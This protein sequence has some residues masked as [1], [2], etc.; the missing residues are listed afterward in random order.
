ML[1][2]RESERAARPPR[3][4]RPPTCTSVSLLCMGQALSGHALLQGTTLISHTDY[5]QQGAVQPAQPCLEPWA[6]A[7][8]R[9]ARESL[10]STSLSHPNV[11]STYKIC[12]IRVGESCHNSKDS[13]E[14]AEGHRPPPAQAAEPPAAEEPGAGAVTALLEA[15]AVWGW[16][17]FRVYGVQNPRIWVQCGKAVLGLHSAPCA[18]HLPLMHPAAPGAGEGPGEALMVSCERGSLCI[19]LSCVPPASPVIQ[20]GCGARAD[21][22]ADGVLRPREPERHGARQPLPA[23]AR[24]RARHVRHP[25]LPHRCGRRCAAASCHGSCFS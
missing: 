1:L 14:P 8:R 25:A 23:Q 11:V 21:V 16:L 17:G 20:R 5:L 19:T 7:A 9:V 6:P 13:A 2:Y 22:A 12:T 3:R 18:P 10:L 24:R 15:R 4:P